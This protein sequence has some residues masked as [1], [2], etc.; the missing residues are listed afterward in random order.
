MNET[1]TTAALADRRIGA[2]LALN[3]GDVLGAPYE[4][5]PEP[6]TLPVLAVRKA[7]GLPFG[8][9]TDDTEMAIGILEELVDKGTIEPNSL[10]RRFAV[11]ARSDRYSSKMTICLAMIRR[12][13][14]RE[15]VLATIYPPEGSWGNGAAMRV[16]P[17]AAHFYDDPVLLSEQAAASALATHTHPFA[18]EGAQ[19]LAAVIGATLRDQSREEA[20][21][22]ALAVVDEPELYYP[23]SR[24]EKALAEGWTAAETAVRLGNELSAL[25]SVPGAIYA[26]LRAE[27]YE[28]A[29]RFAIEMGG[30]TDTQA[31][32]AGAIVG[33]RLGAA[34]I[35]HEWVD[36]LY[37]G[38]RGRGYL[39]RLCR[40][41]WSPEK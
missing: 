28:Q 8:L 9:Y 34:A 16:A 20:L 33:A 3:V 29:Y 18:V 24:V 1:T 37:N 2:I 38:A 27:S 40:T 32:M 7:R 39:L 11:K 17:I 14:P 21:Q 15:E 26:G 25:R 19:A 23:I 5:T 41:L 4:G 13:V 36:S 35:D 30:D 22:E 31:A 10:A 6:F 12:G